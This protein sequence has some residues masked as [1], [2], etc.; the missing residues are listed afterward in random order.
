MTKPG[1]V[2]TPLA[3]WK[4]R[5]PNEFN[6]APQILTPPRLRRS[7]STKLVQ[8]D[9]DFM[10]FGAFLALQPGLERGEMCGLHLW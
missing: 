3:R 7:D 10:H 2:C 9:P 8:N 4:D 1:A 6:E 5:I